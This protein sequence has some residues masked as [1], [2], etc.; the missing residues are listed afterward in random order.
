MSLLL[1]W[2]AEIAATADSHFAVC[3]G[4]RSLRRHPWRRKLITKAEA[5][6]ITFKIVLLAVVAIACG[7]SL[8]SVWPTTE[9]AVAAVD[10][11]AV[12]MRQAAR[13]R[14]REATAKAT[15]SESEQTDVHV[16][17]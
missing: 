14:V 11:V 17:F 9:T 3:T 16:K 4:I 8:L 5:K 1:P 13:I 12:M 7:P 2:A 6:V 15:I 10:T